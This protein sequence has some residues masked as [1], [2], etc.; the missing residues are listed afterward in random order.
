MKNALTTIQI[1][2][3]T[4]WTLVL[5]LGLLFW[6]G[7]D[8]NLIKIHLVI[9]G[10]LVLS[11]WGLAFLGARARVSAGLVVMDV[12]WSLVLPALGLTQALI[13]LGPAHWI[14][15]IVHLLVGIGALAQAEMLG[16]RIK[17]SLEASKI[18]KH[19]TRRVRV[20]S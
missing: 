19:P 15:H 16:G 14:I 17:T 5:I 3:R 12:A 2:I 6:A 11:L 13:L 4:A 7:L 10:V 9:G 18:N 1:L 20:S 8:P